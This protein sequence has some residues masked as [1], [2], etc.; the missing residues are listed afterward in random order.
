MKKISSSALKSTN[1]SK[2]TSGN[3]LQLTTSDEVS[4]EFKNLKY[5]KVDFAEAVGIFDDPD[6]VEA[7]DDR[8]E[9]GETR[10]QALG[11]VGGI[12]VP[13]WGTSFSMRSSI[14]VRPKRAAALAASGF[15]SF[16]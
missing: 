12:W 9:Y 4:F 6:L 15:T 1:D 7:Y 14:S 3:K 16:I 13:R 8:I 10:L 2:Q 11:S 5:L